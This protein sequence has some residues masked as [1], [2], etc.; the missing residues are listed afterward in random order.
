MLFA[1]ERRLRR[2]VTEE[3]LLDGSLAIL[4][5]ERDYKEAL[6]VLTSF[7]P[8]FLPWVRLPHKY[9]SFSYENQYSYNN[10]ESVIG[11]SL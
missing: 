7:F 1:I 5:T 10:F 2:D 4:L 8:A 6:T 3:E 11:L 9:T